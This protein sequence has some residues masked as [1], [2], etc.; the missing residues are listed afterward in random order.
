[1]G[2]LV[3]FSLVF[4]STSFISTGQ[5]LYKM[6]IMKFAFNWYSLFTN[7][8]LLIGI[9]IHLIAFVL[10]N[11]ALKFGSLSFIYP[12]VASSYIWVSILSVIFLNEMMTH[13]MWLG[14]FL[15]IL[16]VTFVSVGEKNGN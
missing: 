14:I 16:G 12:I 11:F 5:I 1:M 3:G 2:K 9:V 7:Y 15:I 13:F 10:F 4:L 6:G 8:P